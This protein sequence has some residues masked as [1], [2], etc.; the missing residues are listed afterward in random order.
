MTV[1]RKSKITDQNIQDIVDTAEYG[2][3]TYWADSS[4][5]EQ[6]AKAPEGTIGIVIEQ[7]TGEVKEF[8]ADQIR[9]AVVEIA[10][11]KHTNDTIK[12]YVVAAFEDWTADDGIDCGHIDADAADAIIQVACF[13]S[14]VYG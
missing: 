12:G 8:T 7:E 11:G 2:G 10:E 1:I 5:E 13:G 6:W 4:T 9:K 14:V 3:I